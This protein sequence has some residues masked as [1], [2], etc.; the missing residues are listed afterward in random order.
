M[1]PFVFLSMYPTSNSEF[2]DLRKA[3]YKLKL[4]DASIVIAPEHST[5][6]GPG[7]RCGF[8]GLLHAQIVMERLEREGGVEV[9]TAPPTIE[10]L[11]DDQSVTSPKDFDNSAREIKEPFINGEI[12]TPAEFLGNILEIINA[13]RGVQKDVVYYATQVKVIFEMPL[14]SV[15]Y[16]FYDKIKSASS[17]FASFDY[18]I[19]EFRKSDLVR[20]DIGL[21]E[22]IIPE[23]SFIVHTSEVESFS[24]R[25]VE[26][27]AKA[28]PRHQF[29]IAVR[30]QIASRIV[31]SEKIAAYRKDVTGKLY[32]GDRT[33]KDK[34]LD[35]Q[36][37]GKKK[38]KTIGRV[39]VPKEAFLSVL[40]V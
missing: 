29:I 13:K 10:Y 36:K 16:D 37:E 11:V 7:F 28:I 21:N 17:G 19:T 33:R 25:I 35:K 39:N 5:I 27:L 6:F 15:V 12:Y 1:K 38:M 3:I 26:E 30:A 20:V 14:A 32:G 31:A 4:N 40:K 34:L 9:F 18:E 23:L 8:L 24:R 2:Q 22:N